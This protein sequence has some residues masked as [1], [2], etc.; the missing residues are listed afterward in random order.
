MR[1]ET[2]RSLNAQSIQQVPLP[3]K[4]LLADSLYYPGAGID[5]TPIR[6][7]AIG[8]N[9]FVYAD[10]SWSLNAYLQ[11]LNKAPV[12][13]YRIMAQRQ[14]HRDE[15]VKTGYAMQAPLELNKDGY[16]HALQRNRLIEEGPFALWTIFERNTDQSESYGPER[17]SLF[18][19]RAEGV[20]TYDGLYVA[21]DCVP[22]TLAFIR[23]GLAFG[24][25]YS[26]FENALLQV[27]MRSKLGL[28]K[29]L[30]WEHRCSEDLLPHSPWG[31]HYDKRIQGPWP[32]DGE[33]GFCVSLW[34][35][36]HE[37]L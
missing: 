33:S 27:M 21:H 31:M 9:S 6:N 25:N 8:V 3:L 11:A 12:R 26:D 24:G 5:G 14:V 35:G 10:L 28:P 4:E 19:L 18:H 20:A 30:L 32:K 7:W 13:G 29:H 1:I 34:V 2:L 17:F 22:H 16:L 23:P 37:V 15:L 36:D